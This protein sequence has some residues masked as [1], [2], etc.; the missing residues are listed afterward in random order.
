MAREFL[1]NMLPRRGPEAFQKFMTA[2]MKC[3][4][5]NYIAEKLDPVLAREIGSSLGTADVDV[6]IPDTP[7]PR[8]TKSDD[9]IIQELKGDMNILCPTFLEFN[10]Q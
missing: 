7:G 4:Q 9:D 3:E 2:L 8:S 10:F 6:D 5:Q 1:S